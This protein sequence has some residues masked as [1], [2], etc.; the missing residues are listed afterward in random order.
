MQ[1]STQG[2]DLFGVGAKKTFPGIDFWMKLNGF[3]QFSC[4][5]CVLLFLGRKRRGL[6][7]SW[8]YFHDT[9]HLPSHAVRL[10]K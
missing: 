6:R 9:Y 1:R 5:L 10:A 2:W 8:V 4:G 3:I 7:I